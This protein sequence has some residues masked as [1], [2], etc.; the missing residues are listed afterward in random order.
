MLGNSFVFSG[1]LP[2][3]TDTGNA[4]VAGR[5]IDGACWHRPEGPDSDISARPDNPVV[6]V[7]WNDATRFAEWAGGRL[8]S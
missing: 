8:P 2:D 4:V 1:F 5:M 7:S 3:A 6:H